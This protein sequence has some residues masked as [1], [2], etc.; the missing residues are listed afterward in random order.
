MR[1]FGVIKREYDQFAFNLWLA[2]HGDDKQKLSV[3]LYDVAPIFAILALGIASSLAL[4]LVEIYRNS[5][6][7]F[8]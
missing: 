4:F 6:L 1:H 2:T 7:V 3:D 5:F 8:K